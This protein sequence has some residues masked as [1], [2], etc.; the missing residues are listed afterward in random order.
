MKRSKIGV[1]SRVRCVCA[2]RPRGRTWPGVVNTNQLWSKSVS[3]LGIWQSIIFLP[4][5]VH[6]QRG[7]I[8]AALLRMPSSMDRRQCHRS[9]ARRSLYAAPHPQF[10]GPHSG[11]CWRPP[12]QLVPTK[13]P[14]PTPVL[15][16]PSPRQWRPLTI[17]PLVLRPRDLIVGMSRRASFWELFTLANSAFD[18][19]HLSINFTMQS[20][21]ACLGALR[22]STVS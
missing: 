6:N 21:A 15:V 18:Y 5:R 9:S 1:S 20:I 19:F 2:T 8:C 17:R 11:H 10:P 13:S 4:L 16:F 22:Q 3:S 14:R 12:R 7:G